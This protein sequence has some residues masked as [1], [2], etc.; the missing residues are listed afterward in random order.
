MSEQ[1]EPN[2][3]GTPT[4]PSSFEQAARAFVEE[5]TP[6]PREQKLLTAQ[7]ATREAI[8]LWASTG[9]ALDRARAV[10]NGP[11]EEIYAAAQA[12]R[13]AESELQKA[14]AAEGSAVRS[15]IE[16]GDV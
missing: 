1:S 10:V 13:N 14:I 16:A 11:P 8:K 6:S 4:T 12:Y 7:G 15:M 3:T 5:H 9:L 2:A